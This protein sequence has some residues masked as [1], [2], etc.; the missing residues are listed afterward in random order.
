MVA[1]WD[2]LF[3][4]YVDKHDD[5]NSS[6]SMEIEKKTTDKELDVFDRKSL[7]SV[8]NQVDRDDA[9]KEEIF[10]F[11]MLESLG[12]VVDLEDEK[13]LVEG[14]GKIGCMW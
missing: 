14:N 11:D 2:K 10:S 3:P 7:V 6:G 4:E 1:S 9:S 13:L 5:A 12:C 8:A